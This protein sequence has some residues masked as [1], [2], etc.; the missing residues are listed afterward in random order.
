[1][2]EF[3]MLQRLLDREGGKY[4]VDTEEEYNDG[5]GEYEEMNL[6]CIPAYED[7]Y[8]ILGFNKEGSLCYI[9]AN[10]DWQGYL[11]RMR[12]KRGE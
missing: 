9:D 2:N 1:M 7:E 10:N 8:L 3:E 12:R 4:E 11:E 5:T 6:L